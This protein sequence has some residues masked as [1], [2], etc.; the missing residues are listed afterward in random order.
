MEDVIIYSLGA[1]AVR[2]VRRA[3]FGRSREER[4]AQEVLPNGHVSCLGVFLCFDCEPC[5][6]THNRYGTCAPHWRSRARSCSSRLR[7]WSSSRTGCSCLG[8]RRAWPS[9]PGPHRSS[10]LVRLLL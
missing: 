9:P 4:L 10:L 2:G 7:A 6:G 1:L 5:P 3:V 8:L